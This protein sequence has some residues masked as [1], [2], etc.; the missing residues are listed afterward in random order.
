MFWR[1]CTSVHGRAQRPKTCT[2]RRISS[3]S[4]ARAVH[5]ANRMSSSAREGNRLRHILSGNQQHVHA[6]YRGRRPAPALPPPPLVAIF[7]SRT[8]PAKFRCPLM[9]AI[10]SP[11]PPL[12]RYTPPLHPQSS[13]PPLP[14]Q[15]SVSGMGSGIR[16]GGGSGVRDGRGCGL[17]AAVGRRKQRVGAARYQ[18]TGWLVTSGGEGAGG[19]EG[20]IHLS[21]A[22]GEGPAKVATLACLTAIVRQTAVVWATDALPCLPDP[23]PLSSHV[24][25]YFAPAQTH[26]ISRRRA[27]IS[28][29]CGTN[30]KNHAIRCTVHVPRIRSRAHGSTVFL[31][32]REQ[33]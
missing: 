11:A 31:H 17:A 33:N 5:K 4:A 26:A 22:D 29:D 8:S 13:P 18:L 20:G 6:C 25:R 28:R 16:A 21:E 27:Q 12:P 30:F 10:A 15:H 1:A 9:P 32:G 14:R 3:H 7:S 19:R 24:P 23:P 2:E